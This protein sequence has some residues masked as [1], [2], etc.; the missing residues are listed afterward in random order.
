MNAKSYSLL[1]YVLI[2]LLMFTPVRSVMAVAQPH[3][4]MASMD[5]DEAS[6]S[7][8]VSAS[9]AAMQGHDMLNMQ[10]HDM[11]NMSSTDMSAL[12]DH[13]A[14]NQQCCCCDNGCLAN[15]DMGVTAS[16][17]LQVSSYSPVFVIA[18]NVISYT[19]EILVRALTPPSRPPANL[20]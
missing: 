1:H 17:V 2:I 20:S 7:M 15:C 8:S 5:M 11:H 16:L 10:S 18:S 3:C 4:D 6:T 13:S 14:T 9:T 19:S 12:T